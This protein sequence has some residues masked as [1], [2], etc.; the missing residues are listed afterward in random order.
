[1]IASPRK[2]AVARRAASVELARR[3]ELDQ[4]AVAQHRDLVGEGQRLR[5]VMR[6]QDRGE[7][8][9]AQDRGGDTPR[10]VSRKAGIERRKR[11]VEKH[12]PWLARQSAGE[13]HPLLLAA[14]KLVRAPVAAWKPSSSTM[15]ISSR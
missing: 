6:H 4:P 12:Q 15:S 5:L 14:G 13:G 7:S 10:M 8:G 3:A 11:L 2:G 9:G 1:M